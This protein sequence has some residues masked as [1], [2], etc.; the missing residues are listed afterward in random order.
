LAGEIEQA[1]E[2]LLTERLADDVE[3]TYRDVINYKEPSDEY[4]W[5]ELGDNDIKYFVGNLTERIRIV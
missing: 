4:D 5:Y 3:G 1:V 2:D